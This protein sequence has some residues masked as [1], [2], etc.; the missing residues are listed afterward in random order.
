MPFNRS[1]LY[2]KMPTADSNWSTFLNPM[3]FD[4]WVVSLI[5]FV[6]IPF[7]LAFFYNKWDESTTKLSWPV[8]ITTSSLAQQGLPSTNLKLFLIC[9]KSHGSILVINYRSHRGTFIGFHE[10]S[11]FDSFLNISN[12]KCHV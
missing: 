3:S 7:I 5:V 11:I 4:S 8:F 9:T 6:L 12:C 2:I 1:C 10:D